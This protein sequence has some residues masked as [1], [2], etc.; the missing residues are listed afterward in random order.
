MTTG[1]EWQFNS[2]KWKE[3]KELFH[4]GMLAQPC[5]LIQILICEIDTIVKGIFLQQVNEPPNEKVRSWNV[6]ELR[7]SSYF[8]SL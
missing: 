4:H 7:V 1:Q 5:F 8:L 2:Y 3:P 6:T